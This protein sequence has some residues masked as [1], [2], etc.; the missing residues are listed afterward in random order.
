MNA[1]VVSGKEVASKVREGLKPRAA[2]VEEKLGRKACL[3]VVLVGDN[4]ASQVYVRSKEQAAKDT[5]LEPRDIRLPGETTQDDLERTLSELSTDPRVDGILLQ[6]PLPKHLSEF[7]ALRAI[8]PDK[9][10]DGLT[11]YNQGLLF[12][13]AECFQ[14]CTP[15]GV[16]RLIDEAHS[17]QSIAGMRA[18]V[19]GRSVLVGKPQAALLLERSCTVTVCHS[20]TRD[21]QEEISR[22]DI[23]VA[24]IGRPEFVLGEWIKAGAIVIDVGINRL[25]SGKLIGDVHYESAVRRAG[26]ITPVP[27]GVGPMTIAMLLENTVQAAERTAQ[28]RKTGRGE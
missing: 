14:P 15:K 5:G 4:P 1:I 21:L 25:E 2:Q 9:D 13:G 3:A 10:V 23:V 26:A 12:R 22:A 7:N 16:M 11:P 6:L 17:G 8:S 20:K 27:G 24:A 28:G 18:L 19:L